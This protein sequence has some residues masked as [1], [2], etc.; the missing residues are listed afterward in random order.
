MY[1]LLFSALSWGPVYRLMRQA[2]P[3]TS[4][5]RRLLRIRGQD[6]AP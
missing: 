2:Q 1:W 3:V 5:I 6:E 4:R